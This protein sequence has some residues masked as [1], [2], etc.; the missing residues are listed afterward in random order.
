VQH[1]VRI[2]A[3]VGMG[4]LLFD[5]RSTWGMTNIWNDRFGGRPVGDRKNRVFALSTG[6]RF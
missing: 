5:G 6:L 2:I 1:L 3:L 4:H